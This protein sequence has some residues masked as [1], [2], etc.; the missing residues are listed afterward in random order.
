MIFCFM[1]FLVIALMIKKKKKLQNRLVKGNS[2]LNYELIKSSNLRV[3]SCFVEFS[4]L[5]QNYG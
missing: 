3:F 5:E 2:A 1:F 4:I